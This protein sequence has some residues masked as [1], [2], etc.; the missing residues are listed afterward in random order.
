MTLDMART[1]ADAV[2]FEGYL[3]YPY[4]ASAVKNRMRWQFGVLAPNTAD[5]SEPWYAQTECLVEVGEKPALEIRVRCLQLRTR[6]EGSSWDEGVV[7]EVP[8]C[9]DR[10]DENGEFPFELPGG[11]DVDGEVT[12]HRS[13]VSGVVRV[14][15][16]DLS[17]GHDLR[18]VRVV[19][20]NRTSWE[21]DATACRDEMLRR[22]LVSTHTMLAVRG[23]AF[24]SLLDPPDRASGAAKACRNLNTWSVLVG[25]PGRRDVLLSSPIILYDHPAVSPHS[26]GDLFDA[27]EID[28]L[29]TLCTMTLT[30]S[31]KRE[32][33]ATDPRAAEIID[34]TENLSNEAIERMH[35][36]MRVP[37]EES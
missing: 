35:G 13:P 36:T 15:V 32:A 12:W 33:R 24:V 31:E 34:R 37:R 18:R 22:S 10:L 28:E 5:C 1:V 7:Q 16:E 20:E 3:L 26:Q 23:G 6:H 4:R 27:A 29:L 19:V 14:D 25:E 11:T 9:L 17:D 21:G 30:E 8:V 2:L